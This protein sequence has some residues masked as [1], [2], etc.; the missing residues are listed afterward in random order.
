MLYRLL[1]DAIVVLHFGFLLFVVGGGVMALR[2]PKLAW[3]HVPAALWGTLIEF[4]GW[5]CPL[6]PLEVGLRHRGGE[7][8]YTGGFIAHYVMSVLYPE[9]L[10]RGVQLVLGLLVAALNAAVYTVLVVRARRRAATAR[11]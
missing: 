11:A 9:G 1:A 2:W 10:T 8:E 4:F 5:T 3:A 6:T 7:A